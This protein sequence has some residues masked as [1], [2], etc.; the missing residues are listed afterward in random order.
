MEQLKEVWEE[1]IKE[2]WDFPGSTV[3]K[4]PPANPGDM[5]WIPDPGRCHMP[6]ATTTEAQYPRAP[7]TEPTCCNY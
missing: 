5:S 4:N 3:N 2:V 6:C 1:K 7:T